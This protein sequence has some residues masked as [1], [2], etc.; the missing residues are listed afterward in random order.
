MKRKF[1]RVKCTPKIAKKILASALEELE[2]PGR[3]YRNAF[4]GWANKYQAGRESAQSRYIIP[5]L[6]KDLSP[7][8]IEASIIERSKA[9]GR[10]AQS[11]ISL[12]A[13]LQADLPQREAWNLLAAFVEAIKPIQLTRPKGQKDP[14][15]DAKLLARYDEIQNAAQVEREFF[16][17]KE[18]QGTTERHL[19]RLLQR[20]KA[21]AKEWAKFK[22]RWARG[23]FGKD[24]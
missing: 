23:T 13:D 8:A 15:R 9:I 7:E 21:E 20:R 22:A 17:P 11:I 1:L 12:Y 5:E 4:A 6:R 18:K 16:R 14:A 2:N 19:R 3:A 24:R 10:G